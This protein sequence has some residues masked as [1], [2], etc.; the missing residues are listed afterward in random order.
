MGPAPRPH[1][2]GRAAAP[3]KYGVYEGMPVAEQVDAAGRYLQ[4]A[5]FKPGMGIA[6]LYSAINAG[7]VGRYGA[8]DAGNGGAPGTVLDKVQNQMG[9]H[10][11]KA[12]QL[13]AGCR[14]RP[15]RTT[16][17]GGAG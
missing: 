12:E 8:S 3:A 13:L 9:G 7:R 14:C 1:P 16:P 11:A 4:D 15:G 5:G 2:V 6:D 10:R 17:R